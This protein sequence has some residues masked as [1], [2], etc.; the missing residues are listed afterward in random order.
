M[1]NNSLSLAVSGIKAG[2]DMMIHE[3]LHNDLLVKEDILDIA[4]AKGMK[5]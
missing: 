2:L 5:T 3:I 1:T 4:L